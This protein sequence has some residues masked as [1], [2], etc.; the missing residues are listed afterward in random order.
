[1]IET[2]CIC[3]RSC[4]TSIFPCI[5]RQSADGT[6]TSRIEESR[7]NNDGDEYASNIETGYVEQ[8]ATQR[9]PDDNGYS[10]VFP[11]ELDEFVIATYVKQEAAEKGQM[12]DVLAS[13][14]NENI[15][16]LRQPEPLHWEVRIGNSE[17]S[18]V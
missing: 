13:E 10:R 15:E 11:Q 2:F 4:V 16:P 8:E 9:D 18:H 7:Y 5:A 17:W 3:N 6:V 14:S 1:M 12:A